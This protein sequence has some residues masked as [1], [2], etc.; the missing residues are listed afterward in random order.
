LTHSQEL[1]NIDGEKKKWSIVYDHIKNPSIG[2]FEDFDDFLKKTSFI[3]LDFILWKIL[4]AT[5]MEKEIITID[6]HGKPGGI[7]CNKSY[8]WIYS[9]RELLLMNTVNPAIAE[10]M[11]K[12]GE[13]GSIEDIKKNYMSSMLNMNNIVEL[14]TSKFGVIFGHISA[15]EYLD[16]VY[17][18]IRSTQDEENKNIMPSQEYAYYTLMAI[19][20]LILPKND[21]TFIKVT[22]IQ[23]MMK[24]MKT[25]NEI[26][27]QTILEL[28]RIM[29]E[30]Y[31]FKFALR[32]ICC[33]HCKTKS[34]IPI[35][36]MTRLLFIVAR[37]LS[38]VQV[39]LKRR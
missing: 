2:P 1:T 17:P 8:D 33:P 39:V 16:S 12:T 4:C 24:I 25:L 9:P 27:W 20:G 28:V 11:K 26:D 35:G 38:S 19:K 10:E 22:D 13:A 3:D 34:D 30:P 14:P 5:S 18:L 32:D 6:C 37:S 29:T 23:N 31:Q 15:Y 21:G 7:L 36:D